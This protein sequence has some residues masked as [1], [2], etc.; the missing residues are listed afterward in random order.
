MAATLLA[1][2]RTD[3]SRSALSEIRELGHIPAVIYG[4][5][6]ENLTVHVDSKELIKIIREVG[7]NGIIS[8]QVED[9][10]YNVI[11]T[12]YQMDS[13][14]NEM[15]HADFLVVDLTEEITVDVTVT[16]VGDPIGERDGGVIQQTLHEVSVTATPN[17]IPQTIEVNVEQLQIGDTIAI[18]DV[19]L[20][21]KYTIDNED[22]EVI[23]TI[24]PPQQEE[25]EDADDVG[26]TVDVDEEEE[27]TPEVEE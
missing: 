13:I 16:L 26:L 21:D 2:E 7:R 12:D 9:A 8:L 15:L 23:V 22:D 3:F 24:L 11:L 18:S 10:K 17:N 19:K 20:S 1:K 25:V 5:E 4:E 6:V 14:R 27:E